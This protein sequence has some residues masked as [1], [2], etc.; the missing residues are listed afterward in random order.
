MWLF[1]GPG[2]HRDAQH[3]K[4]QVVAKEDLEVKRGFSRLHSAIRIIRGYYKILQVLNTGSSRL[5]RALG[6]VTSKGDFSVA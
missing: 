6:R 4:C 5:Y 1:S 2:E 3:A